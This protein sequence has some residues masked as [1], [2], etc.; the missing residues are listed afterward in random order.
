[1]T[2]LEKRCLYLLSQLQ[3]NQEALE[4]IKFVMRAEEKRVGATAPNVG[5]A[6]SDLIEILDSKV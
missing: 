4:Y 2:D 3:L 1:M 5:R 6:I